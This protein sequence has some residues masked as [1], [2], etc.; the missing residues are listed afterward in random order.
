MFFCLRIFPHDNSLNPA[1]TVSLLLLTSR[2]TILPCRRYGQDITY[3]WG[4]N[5]EPYIYDQWAI[6]TYG[7]PLFTVAKTL[8]ISLK[9]T[10]VRRCSDYFQEAKALK[11]P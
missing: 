11:V 10:T 6:F 8:V 1:K 9:R 3:S 4:T 7:V 5:D 2:Y